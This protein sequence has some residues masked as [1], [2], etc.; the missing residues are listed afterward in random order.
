MMSMS[1]SWFFVVA[2]EAITV[3]KTQ[4]ALPGIGAGL[5][6]ANDRGDGRAVA[7]AVATMAVVIV[8]V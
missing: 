7:W 3:G 8:R 4:V 6:V 5:A 1:G 2:C